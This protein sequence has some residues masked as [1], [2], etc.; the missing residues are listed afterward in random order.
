[1]T[2]PKGLIIVLIIFIFLLMVASSAGHATGPAENSY[3][4]GNGKVVLFIN[5]TGTVS[6]GTT[7]MRTQENR[8]PQCR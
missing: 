4:A 3:K 1:M 2:K 8:F 5:L 7:N 6:A